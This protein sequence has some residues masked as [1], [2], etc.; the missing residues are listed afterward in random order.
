MAEVKPLAKS[1]A[2]GSSYPPSKPTA[3]P[4]G[5]GWHEVPNL[6]WEW[7]TDGSVEAWHSPRPKAPRKERT[8]LG[9]LG[10]RKLAQLERL[11]E[12]ERLAT[13]AQ[14]VADR[15]AEKGIG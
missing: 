8:Y 7:K 11:P 14:W 4:S 2:E 3:R 9:R 15:R 12:A 1:S 5:T 13:V 6:V 10:V